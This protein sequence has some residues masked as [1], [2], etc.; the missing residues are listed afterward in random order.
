MLLKGCRGQD[1]GPVS[2]WQKIAR[3]GQV[4]QI[5]ARVPALSHVSLIPSSRH[6]SHGEDVDLS[7]NHTSFASSCHHGFPW[8][9]NRVAQFLDQQHLE[10]IAIPRPTRHPFP[11]LQALSLLHVPRL[12]SKRNSNYREAVSRRECRLGGQE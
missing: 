4:P 5:H 11:C 12:P 3:Q 2:C 1:V 10:Q 7:T 9:S 6:F 8:S